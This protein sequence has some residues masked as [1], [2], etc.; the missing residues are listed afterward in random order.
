M[1]RVIFC[2]R[3]IVETVFMALVSVVAIVVLVIMMLVLWVLGQ[4][5]LD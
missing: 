4:K 3:I 2:I 1:S 5:E